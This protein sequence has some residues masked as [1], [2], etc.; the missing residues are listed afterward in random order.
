MHIP[1]PTDADK[2]RFTQL[3]PEA[4]GVEVKAMFGNLGG[5]VNGH[6]FMGLFG[7]DIGLKLPDGEREKLLAQA[8]SG[9]FGPEDRPMGGYA[10]LPASWTARKALPW[11]DRALAAAAA[12][13]PKAPK[14]KPAKK[15]VER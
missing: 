7:P 5:F 2:I 8:G 1:K 14:K 10:T 13:P 6:M 12:L 11:I 9:P 3:V 4:P 15:K